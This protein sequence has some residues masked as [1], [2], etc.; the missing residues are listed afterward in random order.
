IVFG[1]AP[2]VQASRTNLQE[3]LKESGRG[4]AA[5]FRRQV[6][7]NLLVVSEIA[8]ALILLIGA[9]LLIKSFFKLSAVDP[10]FRTEG[11]VM[12]QFTMSQPRYADGRQR[13]AL[14][15]DIEQRLSALPGVSSVGV[16]NELPFNG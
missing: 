3:T 1:L 7:R 15:Q 9:G 6:M 4:A 16:T 5:G 10:G 13:I 12:M 8:I 2:A 14:S 11:V